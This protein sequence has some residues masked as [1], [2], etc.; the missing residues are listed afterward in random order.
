MLFSSIEYSCTVDTRIQEP[1]FIGALRLKL[2]LLSPLNKNP[3]EAETEIG[4]CIMGF[5]FCKFKNSR[6][7]IFIGCLCADKFS[8]KNKATRS[9][10]SN[11][12]RIPKILKNFSDAQQITKLLTKN[13]GQK[14]SYKS[15]K[16]S[17]AVN[18]E[19]RAS[20]IEY[21][22]PCECRKACTVTHKKGV[23]KDPVNFRPITR[24]S[25]PL[26]I[27]TSALRNSVFDFLRLNNCIDHEYKKVLF[28]NCMVLWSTPP[29]W[30]IF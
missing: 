16:N 22:L 21:T 15:V 12:T 11:T 23:Q 26:K 6:L 25:I 10:Y 27:F 4:Y 18:S 19:M 9:C 29:S 14:T 17:C 28:R 24:E 2:H 30:V 8:T 1:A 20:H 13:S 7:E 3:K 5:I